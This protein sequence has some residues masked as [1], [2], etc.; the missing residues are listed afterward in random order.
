MYAHEIKESSAYCTIGAERKESYYSNAAASNS[1]KRKRSEIEGSGEA[2][3]QG[4]QEK[5]KA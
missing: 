2:E 5:A 1:H 3:T 4:I